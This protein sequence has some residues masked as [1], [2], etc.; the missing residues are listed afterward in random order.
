MPIP[1]HENAA[2][3]LSSG[4]E[5]LFA[6]LRRGEARP[7]DL[8]II[9]TGYGGAVAAATMAGKYKADGSRLNVVVLERGRE[10]LP[11]SF[12][13]GFSSLPGH[14]RWSTSAGGGAQGTREGL[15]DLRVGPDVNALVANGLGGGSL[16][17]AGVMLQ[18]DA[19]QV[20]RMRL[21]RSLSGY[22]KHTRRLLDTPA[23]N[24]IRRHAEFGAGHEPLKFRA[25]HSI[26]VR[27]GAPA[28]FKPVPLSVAMRDQPNSAGLDMNACIGCGD[29]ASG[30]NHNAKLSL[31]TNLL[32]KA[33]RQGAAI[34]TGATVLR[35]ERSD[36]GWAVDVVYTDTRLRERH[37]APVKLQAAKVILAAGAFGSTEI[38]L[39]SRSEQLV[40]PA[41]LGQGF[42]T[43][44]DMIAVGYDLAM[45]SNAVADERIAPEARRVGPTITAR[46]NGTGQHGSPLCF[47]E[48]AVPAALRRVFEEAATTAAL[49]HRLGNMDCSEHA[50]DGPDPC[51]VSAHA[52]AHS[53]VLAVMGD[54][55]AQGELELTGDGDAAAGDGALRVR[56]PALREHPLFEEQIAA[57]PVAGHE[58]VLPNPGWKL[59]PRQM[60]KMI[61]A[62]RGPLTTVHPLGG[63]PMGPRGAG[64]VNRIGQ[65]WLP[66]RDQHAGS[67]VVLDG[68]IVPGALGL[69]PALTIA[70][71]SL[72][73]SRKLCRQWGW[74]DADPTPALDSFSD[75]PPRP[76]RREMPA[77][78]P[79]PATEVE[80]VE[81]LGGEVMLR[82]PD[83]VRDNFMLVLTIRYKR[84]DIAELVLPQGGHAVPLRRTQRL[85]SKRSTIEVF[86]LAQW[87]EWVRTRE[88]RTQNR[89]QPVARTSLRGTLDFMHRE[90]TTGWRRILYGAAA[91]VRNRGG[92]DSWQRFLRAYETRSLFQPA[93]REPGEPGFVKGWL[94]DLAAVGSRAG[95]VRLF[96]Y[97]LKVGSPDKR[98]PGSAGYLPR[99]ALIR[100]SKR[101]TY[102]CL[103]NPLTQLSTLSLTRFPALQYDATLTLDTDF[104]VQENAPLLRVVRQQDQPAALLD[105]FALTAWLARVIVNIHLW[106]FRKPDP[107]PL[108]T[109]QRL[110]GMIA[111]L[112]RPQVVDV[113]VDQ[114]ADGTPVHARLTRYERAD[115][116]L[117][118]VVLIHGYSTSG[119]SFAHE[120]VDPNLASYLWH[121]ERDVWVLDLRTSSGMPFARMP[122]TLDQVAL[123]DIPAAIDQVCR[124][125]GSEQV[126]LMS[127]CMGGA[128]TGMAVLAQLKAGERF[129]RERE[130][131][132]HRIRRLVLSQVGPLVVF[133]QANTFRAF[134]MSYVRSVLPRIQY[135]F[136]VDGEPSLGDELLDRLLA[137]MPYPREE[138]AIENHWWP[139]ADTSFVGTRHRMDALYGRD[140]S[141]QNVD[142]NI[143]DNL[144][145]FFG[146]LSLATIS[147]SIHFARRK[148]ITNHAGRNV[149]VSRES[150]KKWTFPTLC[151]HGEDNGLSNVATLERMRGV[152]SDAGCQIETHPFKNM[153][154]QDTWLGRDAVDVF[155][156]VA[157]YLSGPAPASAPARKARQPLAMIPAA[158]PVWIGRAGAAP[159]PGELFSVMCDP[160]MPSAAWL[161]CVPIELRGK[162]HYQCAAGKQPG[163]SRWETDPDEE[164]WM[165]WTREPAWSGPAGTL[166]LIVYNDSAMLA[167]KV[168]GSFGPTLWHAPFGHLRV[169]PAPVIPSG[170]IA[171]VDAALAEHIAFLHP[172]VLAPLPKP[173]GKDDSVTFALG[174]CQ[175]PPGILDNV[176][177][178]RSYARLSRRFSGLARP[179]FLVLAGDQIYSDASAGLFDPTA[180][181]DRYKRPYEKL[182]ANKY[183]R[184]V[185]RRMPAYMILDD[186]EISDDWELLPD[187]ASRQARDAGIAG[188]C[189][190]QRALQEP[191]GRL[192]YEFTAQ[193]LPF[194][195]CDT[196]TGRQPRSLKRIAEAHIMH[197][198][199]MSELIAWLGRPHEGPRFI[200]SPSVIGLRR[201]ALA[202]ATADDPARLHCDGWEGYPASLYRLLGAVF[203]LGDDKLVFLSGDEHISCDLELTLSS[204]DKTVTVRSIHSSPLYAPYP[205]ANAREDDFMPSGDSFS[206]Q[207]AADG[208]AA[209]TVV[210]KTVVRFAPGSGFALIGVA[211]GPGYEVSVEFEREKPAMQRLPAPGPALRP[212]TL[213]RCDFGRP[214]P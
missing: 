140:F 124:T 212:Q 204:G 121:Q 128:M 188:Y 33:W 51:A 184:T 22:F 37:S 65:V 192:W 111:G 62:K 52:I 32:V 142:R 122:W 106:T 17:N 107:A 80:I 74:R 70:A 50:A 112:P 73:A 38:L 75:W 157:A 114:L 165:K 136:R 24:T 213:P 129:Y 183:V 69:N 60:E 189:K 119:T 15:F 84:R 202:N 26:A 134:L 11:G 44:G 78:A 166:V 197:E 138:L 125:T 59:L 39:R 144:D 89:P 13:S 118:P 210:C 45:P 208:Q 95:E 110:P 209:I 206:F 68:A 25:L 72:R 29:C 163:Y 113:L 82:K 116:S 191:P 96:D 149:Y 133:S 79:V 148:T 16:I 161:V 108:R 186:H 185:L 164:G 170:V 172:G 117:Q 179:S 8:L 18:P 2:R 196:R 173:A 1:A 86:D 143:L 92:R 81:R 120:K 23:S 147:Q 168:P 87:Q 5:T 30:C 200:V 175:Y 34:Y 211:P 101:L 130:Q 85:D 54:D 146:P 55:G 28:S 182:F 154:H 19:A 57:I 201:R 4:I 41:R 158:G 153:G 171:A 199:Q 102:G 31:D 49:L 48:M 181:D 145:D 169:A 105:M 167:N 53:A 64:V 214:V 10:Y 104:L 115:T 193:G 103:A 47:Q 21:G 131:L 177:A 46:I 135:T 35:L 176:P 42:S 94:R 20:K 66:R 71:L 14:L 180:L 61:V 93:K 194:F 155:Q 3:W 152:L 27:M 58:L 178:Y 187:L 139:F 40:L 174:S 150:L 141:L 162:T 67:L 207:Y 83:G 6:Q 99:D 190:Y 159:P 56:W 77:P 63:C 90:P 126:D 97:K 9:G 88:G 7:I 132:P 151:I 198:E 36:E 156:V 98:V 91:W 43:N 100:G 109:A 12:P 127:H 160:G 123:A 203:T 76:A 137:A 195:M 205:F